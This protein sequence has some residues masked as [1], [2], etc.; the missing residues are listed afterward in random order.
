VRFLSLE[1]APELNGRPDCLDYTAEE[2]L[3]MRKAVLERVAALEETV[4]QGRF[5][6]R[7]DERM[8]GACRWCPFKT[9]CRKRHAQTVRRSLE[10]M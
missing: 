4:R 3:A 7:P 2:H 6:I 8:F 1:D 5:C 10:G 9:A